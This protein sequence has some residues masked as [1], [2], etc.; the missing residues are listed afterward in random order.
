MILCLSS[1]QNFSCRIDLELATFLTAGAAGL[2]LALVTVSYQAV[3]GAL[4]NRS[5]L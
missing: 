1:L 4:A 3:R 2:L 5:D